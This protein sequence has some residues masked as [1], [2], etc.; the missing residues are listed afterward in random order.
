M[1][2]NFLCENGQSLRKIFFQTIVEI[3]SVDLLV[4]KI[5]YN[6]KINRNF[7]IFTRGLV[8]FDIFTTRSLILSW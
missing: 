2:K 4:R 5:A 1:W 7:E 8:L 3:I 6:T